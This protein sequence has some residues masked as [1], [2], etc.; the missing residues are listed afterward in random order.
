MHVDQDQTLI[1]DN[2]TQ[3]SNYLTFISGSVELA[4]QHLVV[5]VYLEVGQMVLQVSVQPV[6]I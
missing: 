4:P 2:M 6:L 3:D 5:V 1:V